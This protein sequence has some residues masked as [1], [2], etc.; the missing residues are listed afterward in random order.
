MR[1][2]L[3][4]ILTL[5]SI[6]FYNGCSTKTDIDKNVVAEYGNGGKI[7]F[8]ELNQFVFDL[9]YNKRFRVK[10]EGYDML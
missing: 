8:D 6:Y 4:I 2:C 3:I 1:R 7:T 10:S 5:V 9:N